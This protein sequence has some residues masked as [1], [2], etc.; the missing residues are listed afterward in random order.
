MEDVIIVGE[1]S[2]ST[3]S[4][5]SRPATTA[6]IVAIAKQAA[7]AAGVSQFEVAS[8]ILQSP[9]PVRTKNLQP[10]LDGH[11]ISTTNAFLQDKTHSA[12]TQAGQKSAKKRKHLAAAFIVQGI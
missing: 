8:A 6:E 7:A 12:V 2:S 5:T 10:T 4:N 11:V 9:A 1:S 3:S